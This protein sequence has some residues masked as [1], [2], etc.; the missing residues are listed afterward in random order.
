MHE[1]VFDLVQKGLAK[2]GNRIMIRMQPPG[3]VPKW[4]TLIG[5]FLDLARTEQPGGIAVEQQP[6]QNFRR[7]GFSP[8]GSIFRINLTQI[9]LGDQI[10]HKARQMLFRQRFGQTNCLVQGFCIIGGPKLST[11]SISLPFMSCLLFVQVLRQT[12]R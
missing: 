6:Q 10:H 9:K 4:D 12:A 2:M 11:H 5:G 7:N 1:Q 3:N 8:L